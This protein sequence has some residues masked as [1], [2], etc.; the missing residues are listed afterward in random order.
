MRVSLRDAQ[1]QEVYQAVHLV[2]HTPLAAGQATP[3]QI[4][5]ENPPADA[6]DLEAT[7]A[8]FA[9]AEAANATAQA[10]QQPLELTAPVDENGQPLANQPAAYNSTSDGP[11]EGLAPRFPTEH[12]G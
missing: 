10:H 8:T 12:R 3:F 6:I 11:I 5:L 7:F 2:S 4:R 9:E 1:S